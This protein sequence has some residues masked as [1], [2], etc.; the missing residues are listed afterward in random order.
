[1]NKTM[2]TGVCIYIYI[3]IYI[4]IFIYTYIYI[5]RYTHTYI[6]IYTYVIA[7]N[8]QNGIR[9]I[10]NVSTPS[11]SVCT[12]SESVGC[13]SALMSAPRAAFFSGQPECFELW[14]VVLQKA[15]SACPLPA[16]PVRGKS[17]PPKR[18]VGGTMPRASSLGGSSSPSRPRLPTRSPPPCPPATLEEFLG[19]CIPWH[20]NE[21]L[22]DE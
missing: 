3:Y 17:S 4:D 15:H 20:L 19:V 7:F 21:P 16:F 1:M 6:Y 22:H 14:C 8:N 11:L 18:V 10:C 5:H 9:C 2:N 12:G 13:N